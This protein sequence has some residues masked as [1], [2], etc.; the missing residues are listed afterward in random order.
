MTSASGVTFPAR[1]EPSRPHR[2]RQTPNRMGW[3]AEQ[4]SEAAQ[5]FVASASLPGSMV[6][7]IGCGF[8][9][10]SLAAAVAGARVVA[11]DLSDEVL[12][13][14]TTRAQALGVADRIDTVAGRFPRGLHFDEQRFSAI[15]AGNVLHFLTPRALEEGLRK[16][17]HW[18]RPG[19]RLFALAVT[20]FLAPFAAFQPEYARR[21]EQGDPWPGWI[22]RTRDYSRHRL[23]SQ[24]P[25]AVHLLD[26][27]VLRRAA[28][29]A[30][31]T[32]EVAILYRRRDLPA[33]LAVDG[34]EAVRLTARR[35]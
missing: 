24:T 11:N 2:R 5:D 34:R 8:G 25:S 15:H 32:V 29:E 22:A 16:V 9:V 1:M 10:A 27:D 20:P 4:L 35:D 17:N 23:L 30:G 19:G 7:D 12:A 33:S 6:L 28:E 13:D 21:R 26:A 3:S 14:L 31:F 18:L